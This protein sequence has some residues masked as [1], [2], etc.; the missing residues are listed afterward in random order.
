MKLYIYILAICTL[1]LMSSCNGKNS[2]LA[3]ANQEDTIA[4]TADSVVVNNNLGKFKYSVQ[5]PSTGQPLRHIVIEWIAEQLG[6]YYQGSSDSIL[7][8]LQ[9]ATDSAIVKAKKN[10]KEYSKEIAKYSEEGVPASS[11]SYYDFQKLADGH[12]YATW[13]YYGYD[14]LTGSAHGISPTYGQTFRKNDGRRIGWEVV[15]N[16]D[17]DG[18][19]KLLRDGLKEYLNVKTDKELNDALMSEDYYYI[20]PLPKCPPLFT[21]EGIEFIYNEYE[22][23]SYAQGHPNFVISYDKLRPY[24]KATALKLL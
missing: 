8:I 2:S 12:N 3:K 17:S 9:I 23:M 20:L 5:V 13:I 11:S 24:L 18:F 15:R 7:T 22:I 10:A 14:Y 19:Q 6:G 4:V 1:E 16:I 21:K